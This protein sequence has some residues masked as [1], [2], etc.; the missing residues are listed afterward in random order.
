MRCVQR[1]ARHD[2][3]HHHNIANAIDKDTP[4]HFHSPRLL[5]L[6]QLPSHAAES[7]P[8]KNTHAHGLVGRSVGVRCCLEAIHCFVSG[9]VGWGTNVTTVCQ[10]NYVNVHAILNA[11]VVPTPTVK[12]VSRTTTTTPKKEIKFVAPSTHLPVFQESRCTF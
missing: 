12:S 4:H 10:C 3:P 8:K 1:K 2:G 7:Q 6:R 9:V 5:W 11:S